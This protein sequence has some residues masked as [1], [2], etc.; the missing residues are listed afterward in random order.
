[1]KKQ[2]LLILTLLISV[3]TLSFAQKTV[4]GVPRSDVMARSATDDV[5]DVDFNKI[6]RWIGQGDKR[7]ALVIKWDEPGQTQGL[8][9]WGYRWD[10][11]NDGTG[12]AMI[13]HVAQE[14]PQFFALVLDGTQYGSAIGGLGYDINGDGFALQLGDKTIEP[15]QNGLITTDG[16]NFDSF[17]VVG[18]DD[19][20]YAGW[21]TGYWAY[22]VCN[23]PGENFGYSQ[24]GAT[25]RKLTDGCVDGWAA[26][27]SF[28]DM[29]NVNMVGEL[30]YLP[31]IKPQPAPAD[32]SNGTFIVNED[33]YG[34]QNS[35]VN[36]LTD[37][38]EWIY[39]VVQ[40]ENPGIELGCTNQYGAIYGNKFYLIAKQEKDPGA[41]ITG[42]R[43]TVCDAKTMKVLKQIQNI[44]SDDKGNSIADGR[45]FLG[46]NE[47]KGYVGTSNGIYILDLDKLEV[48]GSIANTGGIN[49]GLYNAQIGNMVR[50]N[51]RVF[52]IHQ[53][54]GLL[55][56]DPE[57]DCVDKTIIAPDERGFG[58][59][60]LSKDG[61][62]WLSLCDKSGMG[63]A[64]NRLMKLNPATLETKII[65]CPQGIY[66]PANS[67]YAWTPDGFCAST[68]NN[69]L[70]W[71]GGANSWFSGLTVYKYDI[72][73]NQF[74][75]FVDYT[76]DPDGWQ[77]Y[78]CSFRIDPETD[79]AFVSLFKS[80]GQQDYVLRKYSNDGTKIAE[81]PMI[82]NYW[83]PSLPVFPDNQKP[84][85]DEIADIN[86]DGPKSVEVSLSG[87]VTDA[88]NQ[89][90]AIITS[91][92]EISNEAVI[93]AQIK[94]GTLIVTPLQVG[95][96][97]IK[98]QANS[99]GLLA[100]TDVN[101]NVNSISDVADFE[102]LSLEPQSV[103][104]GD[105]TGEDW[106][107]GLGYQ[108]SFTSGAYSF[109]NYCIPDMN[110]W[111]GYAYTNKTSTSFN[112]LDD[113]FNSCVGHGYDNSEKY[114]VA[115]PD[116]TMWGESLEI[117]VNEGSRVVPGFYITN[118][119]WVVDAIN[120]GDGMT[121]DGFEA[122]DYYKVT[123]HALDAEGQEISSRDFCLAD[124]RFENA[125]DRY[126]ITD[127]AYVD[128]SQ[129]GE[130]SSYTFTFDGSRKNNYGLTTPTYFC[131]DNFG[132]TGE[133][134]VREEGTY[135]PSAAIHDINV[136][137]NEA[138]VIYNIMGVRVKDMTTPGFYIV[139]G[140]KV[141]KR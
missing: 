134:D 75:T 103:W 59:V 8:Y 87:V 19:L 119:A 7:A 27:R 90:A 89:D 48:K 17:K 93:S 85:F 138:P 117:K 54:Q 41:S 43:I 133:E 57:T 105:E 110:T 6:E 11:D 34:H 77:I 99:N 73:K 81:Y 69:T 21:N 26:C 121:G 62:L 24:I 3:S 51:D 64:D 80:F 78:G 128:L 141:L 71:N 109:V 131:I 56:I 32:Y 4:Q 127:W 74:S 82:E 111:I 28:S 114:V 94:N 101:V 58:S 12:E 40:K 130:A 22:W 125:A 37:N 49:G 135:D 29:S 88:D 46:V 129:L 18:D 61:N 50:V 122:G 136:D 63:D 35:T 140:H 36:F 98:I 68:Q 72:D 9:V 115:Y 31:A 15:D 79:E 132:D 52:A 66:G 30:Y 118:T 124:Y 107:D 39:R 106:Y 70:Y 112:G 20:W 91:I 83:F 55:V 45:G 108:Q 113:Q 5:C 25:G 97:V 100:Q 13:K 44:A 42:A 60:V 76:N 116:G 67:W 95:S 16:Y 38:G 84:V 96:A 126:Y 102:N 33:W 139:N 137:N 23:K 53:N 47:H 1:M 104:V 120:N 65:E 10:N 86:I 92:Q 2:L 123:I 14:D